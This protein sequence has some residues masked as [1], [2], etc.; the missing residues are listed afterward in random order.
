MPSGVRAGSASTQRD[1]VRGAA[2]RDPRGGER[3]AQLAAA[4]VH[5]RES[6]TR[7][8]SSRSSAATIGVL[9]GARFGDVEVDRR[10]LGR[11]LERFVDARDVARRRSSSTGPR[12]AR[13]Q[14]RERRA[15]LAVHALVVVRLAEVEVGQRVARRGRRDEHGDRFAIAAELDQRRAEV[16]RE[17]GG[18]VGARCTTRNSTSASSKRPSWNAATPAAR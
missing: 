7:R 1:R 4:R 5:G 15:R 13:A 3:G 16:E 11:A 10:R 9:G 17:I 6:S 12:P 2:G 18:R 8:A 14:R